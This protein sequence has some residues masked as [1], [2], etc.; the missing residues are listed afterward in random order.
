MRRLRSLP[1]TVVA[2]TAKTLQS[3][4]AHEHIL[5]QLERTLTTSGERRGHYFCAVRR[6]SPGSGA[7]HLKSIAP[8]CAGPFGRQRTSTMNDR[9]K[10]HSFFRAAALT[11]LA[12]ALALGVS[13]CKH[14]AS[15]SAAS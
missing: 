7:L 6:Q 10:P 5:R 13:G 8:Q 12:G 1:A 4:A 3:S 11:G 14:D 9:L 15:A 2:P